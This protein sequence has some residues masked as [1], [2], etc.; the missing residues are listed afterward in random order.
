M[1]I[2]SIEERFERLLADLGAGRRA[3]PTLQTLAVL[4]AMR[5]QDPDSAWAIVAQALKDI[6]D[7]ADAES[8]RLGLPP[9]SKSKIETIEY[10]IGEPD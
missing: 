6:D 5:R 9:Q 2:A 10:V 3:N 4:D 1:E 8:F 7:I